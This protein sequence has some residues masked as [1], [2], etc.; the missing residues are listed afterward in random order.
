MVI[1]SL[2]YQLLASGQQAHVALNSW[3][4]FIQGLVRL[5]RSEPR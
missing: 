5:G 1:V 3:R 2:S 4:G